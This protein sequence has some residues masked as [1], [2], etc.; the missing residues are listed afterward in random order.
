MSLPGSVPFRWPS[1]RLA[2]LAVLVLAL[3]TALPLPAYY[4]FL[5]LRS[6]DGQLVAIPERFDLQA[7]PGGAVPVVVSRAV[8][9]ELNEGEVWESVVSEVRLAA[10]QWSKAPGSSLRLRYAG[11]TA[12]D[13]AV[14]TAHIQVLF[15]ELAPGV[16]AMGGPVETGEE[17][18]DET[19]P[20]KPITKSMVILSADLRE[21]PSYTE[22]FY[23]TLVHELGH[24]VGLQ[25]TF[26]SS[27]M[28]TGVTRSTTKSVPLAADDHAGIAS[29]YPGKYVGQESG[30]LRGRVTLGGEGLHFASVTALAST[31]EAVSTLTLPDGSYE[32]R[33][34]PPGGYH[35]FA[36][37]VPASSD[38]D[39]GPGQIVLP[40]DEEGNIYTPGQGFATRFFPEAPSWSEAAAIEIAAG[41]ATEG[42]D[43][44]VLPRPVSAFRGVT[45]Y[46]FPGDFAVNP[47]HIHRHGSRHFLVAD[48]FN[49][50]EDGQKLDG[51]EVAALEGPLAQDAVFAYPWAEGFLQVN[52]DPEAFEAN[53]PKALL[54]QRHGDTYVQ[55]AA[56]HI[57][58]R[59]PPRIESVTQIVGED[60]DALQISLTG[61]A[62]D[63][64]ETY[65]AE[66]LV[67]QAAAEWDTSGED[68]IDT[69]EPSLVALRIPMPFTSDGRPVRLAALGQDGQSSL[70]LDAEG[71]L[72]SSRTA[73]WGDARLSLHSIG[74]GSEALLHIESDAPLFAGTNIWLDFGNP[75]LVCTRVWKLSSHHI[76]VNIAAAPDAEPAAY[77]LT[78]HNDL[79]ITGT[80]QPLSV[81]PSFTSPV[82]LSGSLRDA[83]TG[84]TVVY[85]GSIAQFEVPGEG[86][87]EQLPLLLGGHPLAA[88][89]NE[90]LGLYEFQIP[91]DF[92]LGL[93]TLALDSDTL[94]TNPVGIE[95]AGL[96]PQ[97]LEALAEGRTNRLEEGSQARLTIRSLVQLPEEIAAGQPPA[98]LRVLIDGRVCSDVLLAPAGETENTA[99]IQAEI[100]ISNIVPT[101][102]AVRLQIEWD[103]RLSTPYPLAVSRRTIAGAR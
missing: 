76:A 23:L 38:P 12:P 78:I 98:S 91:E 60:P 13:E 96:P 44:D 21:R 30:V 7:Q 40:R 54:W 79:A 81:M 14:R 51:L 5:H 77:T 80:G 48:G 43:I 28:S 95:I 47:A 17:R 89:Y 85:P 55:P 88:V 49:L 97:I 69:S 26:T 66:G 62:L 73:A 65:L 41:A 53:G 56:F 4:P 25:H 10:E 101:D 37:A 39:L 1:V 3:L 9:V 83:L 58:D 93:T 72:A 6:E 15:D 42:I 2:R 11:E 59:E 71:I 19:G 70:H 87:P 92:A 20:F 67:V 45:T 27:V 16:I 8:E 63:G 18:L 100:A 68:G 86:L 29:L 50:V 74:A 90:A 94:R 31:G 33:G 34:I 61:A 103:G 35:V 36:Q 84:D 75:S 52:I 57:V 22:S 82:S 46:S 102:G 64:S 32:I 99:E 24:A